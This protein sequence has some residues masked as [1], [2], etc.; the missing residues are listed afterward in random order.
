MEHGRVHSSTRYSSTV[1][2]VRRY[3]V[4]EPGPG[5]DDRQLGRPPNA[6]DL[7]ETPG[8]AGGDVLEE[9]LTVL[10]LIDGLRTV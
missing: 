8:V 10:I 7:S 2:E 3:Q 9:M 1:Y 4:P 5:S 6:E